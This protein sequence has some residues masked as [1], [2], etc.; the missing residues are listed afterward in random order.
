MVEDI[1]TQLIGFTEQFVVPDWGSLVNLIPILLLVLTFLYVTWTLYR[2]ATAGPKTRGK[3]RVTPVPP[4]GVHLPGGSFAPI[5][6]GIGLLMTVIGLVAGGVWLLVGFVVLTITLLYWG[7]EFLREYDRLPSESTALVTAGEAALAPLPPGAL[8]APAGTPPEGVHI[9]APSFRPVLIAIAMTL[10]VGGLIVG[11]WALILGFSALVVTLLGWLR[12]ARREY[13]YTLQADRTGHLDA[14]PWPRWPIATFAVLAWI[15]AG[16]LLLTSSLLPNS[17][18]PAASG[19]P[20]PSGAAGGGGGASAAPAPSLP[21]ADVVE[22]AQNT[23]FVVGAL[24]APADKAFTIAFDNKDAGQPHNIEIKDA[25]GAQVFNGK[26]ITGPAVEVY[27][28]P[29]LP[30]GDYTFVCSVHPNMT[31]TLKAS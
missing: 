17:G 29:A 26:I 7:R 28:V 18:A 21:T 25:S 24:E 27:D 14:G 3:R 15:L 6:G 9:P 8:S 11:G 4:P 5:L 23:A 1:W 13:G 2:Y 22:T 19:G 30:A 20:L 31:G 12:D 10:L 16:G